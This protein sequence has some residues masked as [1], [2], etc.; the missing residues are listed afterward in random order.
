MKKMARTVFVVGALM[1]SAL[2]L[3]ACSYGG[4]ATVGDKVVITRND[5]LLFGA[6]RKIYVCQ[7]GESGLSNCTETEAP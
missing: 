7:V 5:G 6:L 4:L 1:G 2:T 3:G